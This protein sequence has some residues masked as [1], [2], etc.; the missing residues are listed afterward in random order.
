MKKLEISISKDGIKVMSDGQELLTPKNISI[1]MEGEE[2]QPEPTPEPQPKSVGY[3]FGEWNPQVTHTRLTEPSGDWAVLNSI[4]ENGRSVHLPANVSNLGGILSLNI[5]KQTAKYGKEE[6]PFTTG[7]AYSRKMFG[8][9]RV[10]V[11]ASLDFAKDIKNSIWLTTS[12][13]QTEET[14][15]LK[16][17]IECDVVEY[18]CAD[19]GQYNTSR[20]MWLWQEN[21]QSV[22]E[23]KLPHIDF[24]TK[25][26]LSGGSWWWDKTNNGWYQ[27]KLYPVCRNG[28]RLK[29]TNGKYYFITNTE[30][31]KV[32][33]SADLEWVREDGV[34]GKGLDGNKYFVAEPTDPIGGGAVKSQFL[35]G[36]T[37]IAGWHKWS[38]VMEKT[39]IAYL[40]DDREYWRSIEPLQL[41][42]DLTYTL[43]FA[44]ANV[45]DNYTGEH[46]LLVESVTFT[47]K[48]AKSEATSADIEPL[49]MEVL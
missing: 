33:N 40:C 4:S 12:A 21:Q 25:T 10:D 22:S 47:P 15:K 11:V 32:I 16:Q 27:W 44:T 14:G 31:G 3:T 7:L 34:E 30:R 20:G 43:I 5:R 18:T 48:G 38:I 36:K 24:K 28:N 35:D 49:G 1:T 19:T 13:F 6:K 46:S 37:K 26:S 9:G 29:G 17:L 23:D 41:P 45:S 2:E 39:F 8:L 42:D